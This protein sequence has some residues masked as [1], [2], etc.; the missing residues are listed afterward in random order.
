[1]KT[2]NF[3]PVIIG[4]DIG[5]YALVREFHDEWGVIPTVVTAR[6]LGPIQHSQ[7]LDLKLLPAQTSADSPY[8]PLVQG[9]LD[10]GPTLQAEHP[11]KQLLLIANM[12]SYIWEFA[13]HKDAIS[14]YYT[15]T[16]PRLDI[17]ELVNNK[18]KF[19]QLAGEYGLR[20]PRTLPIHTHDGYQT[21]EAALS[22]FDEPFPWIIKPA[23]GKGYEQLKWPGKAKVYTAHSLAQAREILRT[24][25][26]HTKD[27]DD[28]GSF[29]VQPRIE[30]ND[31]YNLS[32]TA[33]VDQAGTV[34]MLGSAQ[35]LLEDHSPT[36]LGNP[37]A[38]IT[39]PYPEI[40]DRVEEF[41]TGIGWHGFANFDFKVDARSHELFLFEMNPRI[42]R[43]SYYNAVAGLNPMRFYVADMVEKTRLAPERMTRSV[44]YSILPKSLVLRYL[45]DRL[46]NKV[47][48]LYKQGHDYD[49]MFN[50]TEWAFKNVTSMKRLSYVM[51]ARYNHYRKFKRNYPVSVHQHVGETSLDTSFLVNPP[52]SSEKLDS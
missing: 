27:V 33:Y 49:P 36:A 23:S 46:S 48:S 5:A 50:P 3:Q 45:D 44:Y 1:M 34:T 16:F 2:R 41:L 39:E 51:I 26:T 22:S 10:L 12:D 52:Q 15:C 47:T 40:Y 38:M 4:T 13:T 30:G 20:V 32:V 17:L 21:C 35:V 37:A 11:G 43:N 8:S 7:I 42:G 31:S 24:L 29:V 19:P 18:V 6:E 25:W 9:L 28:A 14:Q